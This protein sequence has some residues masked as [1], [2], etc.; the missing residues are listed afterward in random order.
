MN[1]TVSDFKKLSNRGNI[2]DLA[3][4]VIIGTSFNAIVTS[5]VED[6]LMPLLL[7]VTGNND[8]TSL[9]IVFKQAT[10]TTEEVALAYGNFLQ[11]LLNFAIIALVI[12]FVLKIITAWRK[13]LRS[14][15]LL[16]E[17]KFDLARDGL[18]KKKL[19]EKDIKKIEE[20]K[21]EKAEN[22]TQEELL[23][24]IRDLLKNK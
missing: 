17:D 5:L 8:L 16:A 1:K 6:V 19:K 4:A 10:E 21:K 18:K 7:L 14:L 23:T 20:L 9:K 12:F 3:V 15:A 13:K 2:I 24:E 11:S 22:P